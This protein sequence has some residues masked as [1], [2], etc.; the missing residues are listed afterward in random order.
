[1]R[2]PAASAR[3]E[4]QRAPQSRADDS[5]HRS[6]LAS[7]EHTAAP[8]AAL[9]ARTGRHVL[10]LNW[11]DTRHPLGGGSENYVE[12]I[13]EQLSVRGHRVTVLCAHYSG[14]AREERIRPAG[15][16][17]AEADVAVVRRGGR[18]TV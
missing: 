4:R 18:L 14:A 3:S 17:L 13:A 12:S 11:R 7:E 15:P 5:E 16:A 6:E 8:N 2:E 1:L 9:G 10:V